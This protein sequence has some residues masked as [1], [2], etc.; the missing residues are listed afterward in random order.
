MAWRRKVCRKFAFKLAPPQFGLQSWVPKIYSRLLA[1]RSTV[2]L[3]RFEGLC[4]GVTEEPEIPGGTANLEQEVLRRT[5]GSILGYS[6]ASTSYSCCN[7]N[8]LTLTVAS[9][10]LTIVKGVF[11]RETHRQTRSQIMLQIQVSY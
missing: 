9:S 8:S 5:T 6:S 4:G 7:Q 1:Q 10:H 3:R 11:Y 2:T